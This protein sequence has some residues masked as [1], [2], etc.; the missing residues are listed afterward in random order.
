MKL[1]I[2]V[3]NYFSQTLYLYTFISKQYKKGHE[4]NWFISF[5]RCF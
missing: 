2:Y 1:L 5:L 4:K 3:K